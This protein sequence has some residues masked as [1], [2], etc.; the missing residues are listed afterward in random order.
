MVYYGRCLIVRLFSVADGRW[1]QGWLSR[2]LQEVVYGGEGSI[3]GTSRVHIGSQKHK[4]R[5]K[6]GST[7]QRE[8][9][10]WVAF[11]FSAN[12]VLVDCTLST[13]SVPS[14]PCFI[15]ATNKHRRTA[16]RTLNF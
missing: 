2:G 8:I 12:G 16:R 13:F 6:E 3:G 14:F 4:E 15:Y 5:A 1:R 10:W 9:G 7:P 11:Q